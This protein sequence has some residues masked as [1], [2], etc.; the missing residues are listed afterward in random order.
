[1]KNLNKLPKVTKINKNQKY[2]KSNLKKYFRYL[3]I[4]SINQFDHYQMI[5]PIDCKE[6]FKI[7]Q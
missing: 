7:S 5:K 4:P 2:S 3:D 1:M 6:V